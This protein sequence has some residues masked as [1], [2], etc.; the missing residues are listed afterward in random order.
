MQTVSVV[1]QIMVKLLYKC[2]RSKLIDNFSLTSISYRSLLYGTML[3]K[4]L[5]QASTQVSFPFY[6]YCLEEEKP[7]SHRVV[8]PPPQ[9]AE[10]YI[11]GFKRSSFCQS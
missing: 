3:I 7:F 1:V 11:A 6:G 8:S 2:T 9:V 4:P 10:D 5:H